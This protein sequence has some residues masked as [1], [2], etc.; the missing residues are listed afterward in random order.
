MSGFIDFDN[1]NTFPTTL[2]EWGKGFENMILSRVSLVGVSGWWQIEHQVY[3]D[4]QLNHF[5][6]NGLIAEIVKYNIVRNI[7][8]YQY[9]FCFTGMTE[10]SVPA[11]NIISIRRNT[12]L[13]TNARKIS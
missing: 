11:E 12:E 1:P 13:Y 7:Y 3:K 4:D 8:G 9:E 6:R 2:G 5:A 10:G